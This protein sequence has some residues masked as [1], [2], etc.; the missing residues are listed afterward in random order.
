MAAVQVLEGFQPVTLSH[1]ADEKVGWIV[2][3]RHWTSLKAAAR[4]DHVL[5]D[6][7]GQVSFHL[8]YLEG[9]PHPHSMSAQVVAR[10]DA[11]RSS[12]Y[13]FGVSLTT[14]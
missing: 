3:K 4:S 5:L 11:S 6:Y 14:R 13:R 7:N 2:R 10:G 9:I 12:A 1:K 8:L